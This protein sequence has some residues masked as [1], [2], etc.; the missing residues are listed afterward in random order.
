MAVRAT[1]TVASI[2][3]A[4][5]RANM[6]PVTAGTTNSDMTMTL[7]TVCSEATVV[8]ATR[9]GSRYSKNRTGIPDA[10]ATEAS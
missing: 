6:L 2:M 1:P 4:N 3:L 8:R 9:S 5:R 10:S 7:P